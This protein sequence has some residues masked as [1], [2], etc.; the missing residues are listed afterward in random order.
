MKDNI[1]ILIRLLEDPEPEVFRSV[2]QQVFLFGEAAIPDLEKATLKALSEDHFNRINNILSELYFI[3]IK[4][5]LRKWI[6]EERDLLTGITLI[7]EIIEPAKSTEKTVKFLS[8]LRNEIWIELSNNLTALEKTRII[9]HF[10]FTK[11]NFSVKE[12]SQLHPM[13]FSLSR[14]ITE[15]SGSRESLFAAYSIITRMLGLPIF[16]VSIPNKL[17]LSYLDIPFTP[18]IGFEPGR[19][20]PLFLISPG[21]E[22]KILSTKEL[23]HYLSKLYP[24][25]E[26]YEINAISDLDFVFIYG[27]MLVEACRQSG[28][29]LL[30]SQIKELLSL[31]RTPNK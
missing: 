23:E 3:R 20:S 13:N 2:S 4:N 31:W 11:Y 18:K 28:K 10:F 9:N 5:K 22:G 26:K 8:D 24:K 16:G 25:I 30:E 14:L 15:R 27:S 21:E 19:V 29:K 6:K 12:K 17:L 1:D 7:T